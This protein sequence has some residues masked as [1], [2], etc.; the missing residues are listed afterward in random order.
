MSLSGIQKV[1]LHR[2]ILHGKVNFPFC[3]APMVGLSH[4]ALRHIVRKYLP[5]GA[6]TIWPTEMLN[7]RRLPSEKLGETPETLRDAH[8]SGLVPQILGNEEEFIAA[9]LKRLEAWGAEGVDIN[10]GCPVKKALKHNYGVALMGNLDYA[11]EVVQMAVRNTSLPISVKLRAG[12]QKDVRFLTDFVQALQEAGAAWLCLHPRE[13]AQKRRGE[14][15]WS[16]ITHAREQL[17]IALI[18]NGDVQV[19]ED[20]L[21]MLQETGCDSVMIGR[22]LTA[23]PW[24]LWQLGRELG[25]PDPPGCA[26]DPPSTPEEEAKEYGECLLELADLFQKIFRPMIAARKF[27]FYVKVSSAWLPFGHTLMAAVEKAKTMEEI[28]TA[29]QSFF[30]HSHQMMKRTDLRY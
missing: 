9:S 11:A 12:D 5:A 13:A 18:G 14:A 3:L 15:D 4:Y 19:A 17:D 30:H 23:R 7:S 21:K 10:M 16:Q 22:A 25:W 20:A 27:R 24:M 2:P 1:G 28:K 8:E 26:G 6:E 29:V